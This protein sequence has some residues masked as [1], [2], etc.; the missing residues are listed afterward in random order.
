[1]EAGKKN[2]RIQQIVVTLAV[3]LFAVKLTAYFL[4]YSVAILTDALESIVNV[5]AG[6]FGLYS[7]FLSAKPKDQNHPYGHGKI[8]F[9]SAAVEGTLILIAGLLIISEA[10]SNLFDP[11][12]IKELDW[13]IALIAITAVINFVIGSV[14]IR[15]GTKNK[16]IALIA[17]GKHLHTDT[18]S[19]IGIIIGLILIYFTNFMWIDSVVAILFGFIII[20]TGYTIIRKSLAGIMDESDYDLMQQLVDLLNKNRRANWIDLHNTRVIKFGSV[21][22]LDA[23]LTVPWYF[24]VQEAHDEIDAL[25]KLVRDEF[26]ETLELYVHNDPCLEFSCRVCIKNDCTVRKHPLERKIEWTVEN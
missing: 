11:H 2:I 14:C 9:I 10:I 19:T 16:S 22:H 4:T 15:I 13:G 7:L 24:N 5:V 3:V 12:Q 21:L 17:G 25:A 1:M 26:G 6:F 18:Y 20:F 8:E 23:H